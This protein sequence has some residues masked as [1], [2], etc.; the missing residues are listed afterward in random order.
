LKAHFKNTVLNYQPI[1]EAIL[2]NP[3][4]GKSLGIELIVDTG[5][6]GGVLIPLRTYLSLGLNLHEEPKVIAK[7]AV[8]G[9][10]E[11][12]VS[13]VMVKIGNTNVSCRAYTALNVRKSLL[14]REVLKELGLL[15]N[16]PETLK[17]GL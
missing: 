14:G 1:V 15:Y 9:E 16:P 12:R 17:V 7:S 13:R 2:Q 3:S 11:L 10:V 8:G 5:F 4:N 6:Q